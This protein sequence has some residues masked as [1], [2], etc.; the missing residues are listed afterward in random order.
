MNRLLLLAIAA[1]LLS[2][3]QS[4]RDICAQYAGGNLNAQEAA[5]RL[6]L[7]TKAWINNRISSHCE[8]YKN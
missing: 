5:K 1:G 2:G 8:F 3:C 7:E 6:G 4:R